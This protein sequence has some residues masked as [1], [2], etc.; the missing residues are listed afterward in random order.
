VD[1]LAVAGGWL[2]FGGDGETSA[3]DVLQNLATSMLDDMD[4]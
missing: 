1:E 4:L 3:T 2:L